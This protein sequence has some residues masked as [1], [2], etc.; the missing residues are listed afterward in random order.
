M[1]DTN[2]RWVVCFAVI[3][4]LITSIP[5]L[6]GYAV[7]GSEW[8][9]TG[10]IFGVED[11]N[12]YIG[13]MLRGAYGGWL[14]TSPYTTTAQNG[15]F[16]FLPYTLL[17]KLASQPGMHAQ[18]VALFQIFRGVGAF[19]V[20]LASYDLICLFIED[21]K[22]RRIALALISLGGGLGWILIFLI[23]SN[24]LSSLPLEFYSPE[25]FGFL[26]IYGLPHLA[27]ARALLFWGICRY[28]NTAKDEHAAKNRI[29]GGL[30]WL[31][32]GL[33]QPLAVATGW[34][35]LALHQIVLWL[36]GWARNHQLS[37]SPE[38]RE[39]VITAIWMG[40]ISSPIVLYSLIASQIDPFFVAWTKQNLILSPN[41]L[42]YLAAYLVFLP[43]V[44]KQIIRTFQ[45]KDLKGLFLSA[46]VIGFPF[47]AYAPHNLQRRLPEGIWAAMIILAIWY[48]SNKGWG[49]SR[50]MMGIYAISFLSTLLVFAGGLQAVAR[51][52]EPIYIPAGEAKAF[53]YFSTNQ[54][55]DQFILADYS[56]G[57]NLPAWAP[58]F[59]LV[60][61]GPESV[62]FS[63]YDELVKRFFG[64]NVSLDERKD[65]LIKEKVNY[66]IWGPNEQKENT[67]KPD[68][69][70]GLD[71]VY[72]ESGY[73]VYQVDLQG[74]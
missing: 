20:I 71:L 24:S 13:K 40:L 47:L 65:I 8:R 9:F 30:F 21:E 5:Y 28:L 39:Y 15:L 46:W 63:K 31:I 51:P 55:E 17:G 73:Q 16:A 14:F 52:S 18:L 32:A 26:Q 38:Q 72:D 35:L 3:V 41:P 69:I 60:G 66:L 36:T 12:S 54:I 58:E 37:L 44:L 61:H 11:G 10:F 29:L 49:Q 56:V 22:M 33:F 7:Q 1:K 42:Y 27:V 57:N 59:V 4:I 45:A 23:Q 6:L 68:N 53:Q 67:W 19:L 64:G 62:D 74:D 43:F 50:W 70:Q 2:R 34:I 25:S 48:I